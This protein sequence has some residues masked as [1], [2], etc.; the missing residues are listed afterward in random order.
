MRRDLDKNEKRLL[1]KQVEIIYSQLD[2]DYHK[3]V[4][5]SYKENSEAKVVT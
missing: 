4:Y 2:P 5:E 3:A 1:K